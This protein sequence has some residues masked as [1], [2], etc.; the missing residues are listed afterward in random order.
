MIIR[1]SLEGYRKDF[2]SLGNRRNENPPIY[3]DNACST[4]VPT[5]VIASINEYYNNYP[6][7]GGGRSRHW[8]AGEVTDRIEG[9]VEKGIH[10]SRRII[11]DFIN[12]RSEREIIFTSNTTHSINTVALGFN[13]RPGDVVLL[14]DREHNS[15]LVPWLRLQRSGLISVDHTQ[16]SDDEEF[17]LSA[18]E[19]KLASH[20]VRLVSMAYTSNITGY[21][22]PAKEIIGIA[23]RY[24]ARVLLDG[25]QAV[26]HK[27]VDV[28]DLD[29]DFLVFSMHK[30]CG[31]RG[32]G[33][34]YGKKD[35]LGNLREGGETW[36]DEIEPTVL[37]GGTVFDSTYDSYSLLETP[38]RFEAG[39]CNYPG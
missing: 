18:F 35:L 6:S 10:G 1:E 32:V 36:N 38:H 39:T 9:N 19:E 17:D 8:F 25:A 21:T 13:F 37:G 26:P 14:T 23:H 12:A 2:P 30:M 33:V 5:Q 7:C 31:P 3:L 4:L 16:P 15:N 28:Q 20:K 24:G 34:L 11:A 22:V 27:E 29:V